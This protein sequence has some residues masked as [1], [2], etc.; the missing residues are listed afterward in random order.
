MSNTR[1]ISEDMIKKIVDSF[2]G[3]KSV[4]DQ[5]VADKLGLKRATVQYYRSDAGIGKNKWLTSDEK[6]FIDKSLGSM[7]HGEIA[8]ALGRATITV[9][10]YAIRTGAALTRIVHDEEVVAELNRLVEA[11]VSITK[12]AKYCKISTNTAMKW[13]KVCT[14]QAEDIVMD[15]K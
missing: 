11:G 10:C 13:R 7:S 9:S 1:V 14:S 6:E 3:D 4:T 8:K 5:E 15:H 2:T 12:A